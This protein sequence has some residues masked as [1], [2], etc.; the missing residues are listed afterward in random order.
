MANRP[1]RCPSHPDG[2]DNDHEFGAGGAGGA[3]DWK[4][5]Y[6]GILRWK[7]AHLP[8]NLTTRRAMARDPNTPRHVLSTLS[9]TADATCRCYAAANPS[10]PTED[11]ERLARTGSRFVRRW[12]ASNH[13]LPR[14][15]FEELAAHEDAFTRKQI[16][17]NP[18]TP[19]EILAQLVFDKTKTVSR[20]ARRK[21]SR[22]PPE[23]RALIAMEAK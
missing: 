7:A 4:C 14:H 19:T 20:I 6:C 16:A 18:R 12:A 22:L 9:K 23:L 11:V 10:T 2:N 5:V 8:S 1:A 15:L 13:F 17:H 3:P 21:A